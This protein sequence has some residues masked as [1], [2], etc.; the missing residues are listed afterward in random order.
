MI[1]IL[2]NFIYVPFM[3]KF[4]VYVKSAT[5]SNREA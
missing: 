3:C 1:I 2:V 5:E 4:V